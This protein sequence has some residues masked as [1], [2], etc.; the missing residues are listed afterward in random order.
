MARPAAVATTGTR[1]PRPNGSSHS[2]NP[3][4]TGPLIE[5]T[6]IR[7]PN[8]PKTRPSSVRGNAR[9]SRVKPCGM[10]RAPNVP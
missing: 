7:G 2:R 4:S 1:Q 6:T 8:S 9:S 3:A 10:S 5:L